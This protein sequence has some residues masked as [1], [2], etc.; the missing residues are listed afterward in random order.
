M[1][2]G[3]IS[4]EVQDIAET[5]FELSHSHIDNLTDSLT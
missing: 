5:C 4:E 2:K 3:M 1:A